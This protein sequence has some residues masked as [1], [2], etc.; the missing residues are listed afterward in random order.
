MDIE[1]IETA[2]KDGTWILLFGGRT[3]EY[4]LDQ[5]GDGASRQRPVVGRWDPRRRWVLVD[6]SDP[7]ELLEE[8]DGTWVF[9]YWDGDWRHYVVSPTHWAR[10]KYPE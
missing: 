10:L 3:T 4:D 5:D 9:S 6:E 7:S 8:H 2:P 1:T